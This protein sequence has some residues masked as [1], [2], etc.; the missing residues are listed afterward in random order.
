[1]TSPPP[2]RP[3]TSAANWSTHQLSG[4]L[5]VVATY[6][7]AQSAVAAAV[8][9]ASEALEAE[10]AAVISEGAVVDVVGFPRG[11]VPEELLVA[12]ADGSGGRVDIPGLGPLVAISARVDEI[13]GA[14]L[15]ARSGDD[16]FQAEEVA[17][18]RAMARTLSMTLR[19]IRLLEHE[20]LL[21]EEGERRA[22]DNARLLA[23]LQERQAFLERLGKIQLSITRRAPLPEVLDTIVAGVHEL[24]GDDQVALRLLDRADPGF[25]NIVSSV[26]VSR[27][28]LANTRRTP[29]T[30]GAGGRAIVEDRLV[31][32]ENYEDAPGVIEEYAEAQVRAAMAAPVHEN[33]RPIG[34][35]VVASYRKDREYT[36]TEAEMLL[37][38][39][40]HASM[41][42]NDAKVLDEMRHLAYHDPLTGLPNR[43]LFAEHLERALA[44][45]G[46][47]GAPL[48]V[49]FLDLDRFKLVND[50]LGHAIGD[51]LLVAVGERLR[52]CLR[53]A[54]LA[55]RLGGDEF[56]VLAENTK[57]HGVTSLAENLRAVFSDPFY[58]EGHEIT[59]SASMGVAVDQG[60]KAS[61]DALLRNA[62]LAMY[63]AKVDQP[64]HHI[65]FE[66]AM[67]EVVSDRVQLEGDLRRAI[68]AEEFTV[69]YQPIVQLATGK[70]AGVEALVRWRRYDGTLM[71]PGQFIPVAEEMGLIAPIGKV[72]LRE[73]IRQVR[74]WQRSS[75][76]L[77]RLS[78]NINLSLRQLYWPHL[79]DEVVE[80]LQETEFDPSLLTF[81]ITE[82]A[83]MRDTNAMRA[84]LMELHALGLHFA[85]DDFGTGYSSL[86]YLRQFP[87]DS[88][89]IDRSFTTS[90]TS[91][92]GD[93]SVARAIIE[94]G[95]TLQLSTVAE[96][97]ETAEQ[98]KEL[99]RIHCELGQ[100][101]HFA[102]PLNASDMSRFLEQQLL[103]DAAPL[104]APV[105][106]SVLAS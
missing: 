50:S 91:N 13:Q 15:L 44:N 22:Q 52:K 23:M 69:A 89:K 59:I 106:R 8:Q 42:L 60:G 46:R 53:A 67:H 20:R 32:I 25:T 49:L 33:G 93:A 21:R 3:T 47:S 84:R 78:L 1:L 39:A 30:S 104:E 51:R 76:L 101:F 86:T 10:V 96:G 61:A 102:R 63:R 16:D 72:V 2:Q 105:S 48:A 36:D 75:P 11:D 90:L 73:A 17:L 97:V 31:T 64:G 92:T 40:H 94:L 62:D 103:T 71:P 100:G 7:T 88:L 43:V 70:P 65:V 98:V 45:A 80:S 56:A 79:V 38:L 77:G 4:F 87:I 68:A 12:M 19:T 5:V 81:E 95:N 6:E 27:E 82:T 18:L 83:L 55:A 57:R 35:I 14:M 28:L 99:L 34:S 58:V 54:D 37:A 74:T 85:L 29:V 26:G 66:P 24:L 41:A 9:W